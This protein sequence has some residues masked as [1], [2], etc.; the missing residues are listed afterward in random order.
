MVRSRTIGMVLLAGSAAVQAQQT[1]PTPAKPADAAAAKADS[2][3]KVCRIHMDVN[4]PRRIC[5]TEEQWAQVM[6]ITG[7]GVDSTRQTY[8][9][10]FG[11]SGLQ[12]PAIPTGASGAC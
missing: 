4:I 5:L 2:G 7:K 12:E 8:M 11:C 1:P 3:K 10:R 6:G 9:N